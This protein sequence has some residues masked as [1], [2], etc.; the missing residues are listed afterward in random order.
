MSQTEGIFRI[1]RGTAVSTATSSGLA[2][3]RILHIQPPIRA[4]S[5]ADYTGIGFIIIRAFLH[6]KFDIISMPPPFLPAQKW[7]QGSYRPGY[8]TDI[9][10]RAFAWIDPGRAVKGIHTFRESHS[11]HSGS[12]EKDYLKKTAN[13][14]LKAKVSQFGVKL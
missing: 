3:L 7:K 6:R 10:R 1:I 12:S 4:G 14:S 2:F 9:P 8:S 11:R 13:F 5:E